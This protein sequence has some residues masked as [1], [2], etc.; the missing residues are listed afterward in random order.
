MCLIRNRLCFHYHYHHYHC[1]YYYPQQYDN[2]NYHY[3]SHAV[4]TV[5]HET[6]HV[7]ITKVYGGG[8][9]TEEQHVGKVHVPHHTAPQLEGSGVL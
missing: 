2:Y 7:G 5:V 4:L 9:V 8:H 1:Y 3:F 6:L